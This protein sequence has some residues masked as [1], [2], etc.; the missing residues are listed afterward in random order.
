MA[1]GVGRPVSFLIRFD[2]IPSAFNINGVTRLPISAHF[3][4]PA[5]RAVALA[6][7]D[8]AFAVIL[9]AALLRAQVVVRATLFA[10][11]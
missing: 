5:G 1:S 3:A 10:P 8:V 11:N 9:A 4:G 6:G 7:D 2:N